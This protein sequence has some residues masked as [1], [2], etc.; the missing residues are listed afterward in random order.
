VARLK[1]A[2][3]TPF[4]AL[5]REAARGTVTERRVA[6]RHYVFWFR[7]SFRPSF[8]G[9]FVQREGKVVLI[10][11]FTAT[12]FTKAFMLIWQGACLVA[13]VTGARGALTGYTN[14]IAPLYGVGMSAAGVVLA[15]ASRWLS[16]GDVAW[17][18]RV[19]RGALARAA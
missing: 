13:I 9:R 8:V 18:S 19:V 3:T 2:T 1:A 5:P 4:L 12:G 17:L 16:R 11:R 6:L 10:G 15:R 14:W 7:N